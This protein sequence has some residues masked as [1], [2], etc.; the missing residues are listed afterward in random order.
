MNFQPVNAKGAASTTVFKCCRRLLLAG[1]ALAA[2]GC[3][4]TSIEEA[5]P[6]SALASVAA[7]EQDANTAQSKVA[8]DPATEG[9]KAETGGASD[10]RKAGGERVADANRPD[11]RT[12]SDAIV[13][14]KADATANANNGSAG[15]QMAKGKDGFPDLNVTPKPQIPQISNTEKAKALTDLKK[16]QNSQKDSGSKNYQDE[17]KRLRHLAETNG[18]NVLRE[19]EGR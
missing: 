16:A 3:A 12:E 2:S 4:S 9:P 8:S 15:G 14:K 17:V 5:V 7:G 13:A 6:Q 19:I 11:A 1:I 10:S 18:D